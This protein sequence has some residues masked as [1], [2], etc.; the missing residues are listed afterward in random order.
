[1]KTFKI[2]VAHEAELFLASTYNYIYL[3]NPAGAIKWLEG[4][5]TKIQDLATFPHKGTVVPEAEEEPLF[6]KLHQVFFSMNPSG[7]TY[8]I[9]YTIQDDAVQVVNVITIRNAAQKPLKK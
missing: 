3:K 4:I 8:R 1:M 9:I 6:V 2:T 7:N 5:N